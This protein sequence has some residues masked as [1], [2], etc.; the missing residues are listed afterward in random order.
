MSTLASGGT[1]LILL[2]RSNTVY[3]CALVD[4]KDDI[5]EASDLLLVERNGTVYKCT[6]QDWQKAA[7]YGIQ[8][9][10]T[11]VRAFPDLVLKYPTS[12]GDDNTKYRVASLQVNVNG[13]TA[14]SSRTDYLYIGVRNNAGTS[15]QGDFCIAAIQVVKS[16]GTTLRSNSHDWNFHK[17]DSDG[18]GSWRTTYGQVNTTPPAVPTEPT[19]RQFTTASSAQARYFGRVTGTGSGYTGSADGIYNSSSYSGGGGTVL[20]ESVLISQT[21]GTYYLNAETSGSTRYDHFW[22]RTA[23]KIEIKNGDYIRVAYGPGHGQN[24][25]NGL[26]QST[27]SANDKILWAFMDN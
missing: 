13:T 15:Y 9:I 26:N 7:P 11:G 17:T 3:K 16:D 21:S 19:T 14:G 20:S 18:T 4:R 27:S 8:Q 1:D 25:T 10:D 2:E 24:S 5:V 22:L 12:S 6:Y 23:S